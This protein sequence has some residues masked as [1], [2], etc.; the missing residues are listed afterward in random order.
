[1]ALGTPKMDKL[2]VGTKLLDS[3]P[4][5]AAKQ[6]LKIRKQKKNQ[7]SSRYRAIG[8]QELATLPLLKGEIFSL[9]DAL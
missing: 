4:T 1:M 7:G 2:K 9:S 8:T 5:F 6:S 3:E